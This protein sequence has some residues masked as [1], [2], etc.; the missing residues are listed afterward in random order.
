MK[1]KRPSTRQLLDKIP[2]HPGLYRHRN[3]GRYYGIKKSGGKR[4]EHSLETSDRKS[5]ERRLKEWLA[6]LDDVDRDAEKTTLK[7]LIEKF[8]V[9]NR[10]KAP[11]TQ[12]TNQS[13]LN[14]LEA[15][16]VPGL[17]IRV[18]E[19]KPSHLNE[20]LAKHE[21]RIKNTTYNRYVGLLKQLFQIAV[22]DRMISRSP[23][24]GIRTQWKKP[25]KPIRRIPT[26]QQFEAIVADVRQQK[27]NADAHESADFLEFLGL[28]GLGQAEASALTWGDVD[29]ENKR[30]QIRRH[31]TQALFYVPIYAHLAPLLERLRK[32]APTAPATE[33][34][35]KIRDAKKA[36]AASCKRLG[37]PAF[38][39]RNLRQALIRRLWQAGVDYKLISKW[40][41]HSDGGKLILDT[42]TEVLGEKDGDY[43]QAQL[44]KIK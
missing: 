11:K 35:F 22:A 15:T 6:V 32:D 41:G 33:R 7:Q 31:K 34:V 23:T 8:V 39:Q 44:S 36:L 40:Q 21:G 13:I 38:S 5:A 30:S 37:L 42:Y 17:S 43:E 10:G 3:S 28:A 20:W 14:R 12:A 27:L 24:E 25:Q 29:W 1:S 4:K 18:S 2:N 26:Q 19:V 9:M 16:W